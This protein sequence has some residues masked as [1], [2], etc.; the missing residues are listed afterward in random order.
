MSPATIRHSFLDSVDD[1]GEALTDMREMIIATLEEVNGIQEPARR[2]E[3]LSQAQLYIEA[4]T[5]RFD[6]GW[7]TWPILLGLF[8]DLGRLLLK[9][10]IGQDQLPLPRI[11]VDFKKRTL[12]VS[13]R[14]RELQDM[15]TLPKAPQGKRKRDALSDS[16][17]T[18]RFT[19]KQKVSKPAEE[20][21]TKAARLAARTKRKPA[22]VGT[23]RK[24]NPPATQPENDKS[25]GWDKQQSEDIFSFLM[26]VREERGI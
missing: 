15:A 5:S 13:R 1:E 20:R 23:K 26:K 7:A 12:R 4:A 6:A 3:K 9:H 24:R 10:Q 22:V 2:R 17:V 18:R 14:N 19:K 8:Q 16:T 11:Q 21:I 25:D